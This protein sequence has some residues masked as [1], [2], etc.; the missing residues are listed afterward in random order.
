MSMH[1]AEESTAGQPSAIA[2]VGAGLAG[3]RVVESLR[4]DGFHGH[5]VLVGAEQHLPYDRPPLSKGFLVGASRLPT[6]LRVGEWD[7]LAVD[8]RLGERV[9]ALEGNGRVL[10]LAG[11]DALRADA[12]V[13]AT[14]AAARVLPAARG[15]RGVFTL[16]TLDDAMALRSAL[17]P[18]IRV[19]VVGAGFVGCEVAM[20]CRALS[21]HV[22]LVDPLEAPLAR[23]LGSRVGQ[24]IARLHAEHGVVV[25]CGVG[26]SEFVGPDRVK[27]VV[28]SDGRT[29]RADVVVV[30]IGV[31][32]D[33]AWLTDSG[34]AVENGVVC[35]EYLHTSLPSVWA[36]G[37]VAR[38][39]HPVTGELVRVEHWTNAADHADVVAHNIM[40]PPHL[41]KVVDQVPYFWSDQY[42]LKVQSLGLP[43]ADCDIVVL[44]GDLQDASGWV[45]AYARDGTFTAVVGLARP[46][47]VM[48]CRTWLSSP[49]PIGKVI[50]AFAASG[51]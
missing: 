49:T 29:L 44:R 27:A 34:V 17:R 33:V 46:R 36:A 14:G 45:V 5:L 1:S 48:R 38:W 42:G 40:N 37:D 4:E 30:G 28:L 31:A 25:E 32:P 22:T 35:D 41:H 8:L 10:R 51:R 9:V 7:S 13:V 15:L 20:S 2:V 21:A 43:D 11:G 39:P 47:D 6:A 24:A 18:G 12:V 23:V 3:V 19:V 50:E 16:R 26:V